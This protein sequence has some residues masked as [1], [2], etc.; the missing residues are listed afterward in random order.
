MKN[1][2]GFATIEIILVVM[3]ISLLS[4]ISLPNMARMIDIARL[5][6]EVKKFCSDFD[7]AHSL[8]RQ[9]EFSAEI[10]QNS[11]QPDYNARNVAIQINENKGTYQIVRSTTSS[12]RPIRDAHILSDGIKIKVKKNSTIYFKPDGSLEGNIDQNISESY[13]FTSRYNTFLV[14][15]DSVG[16]WRGK[17]E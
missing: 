6:Y 5:D 11:I 10:F 16:R 8:G 1:Q 9:T 3:I 2:G 12:E 4:T 15:I 7:F 13:T 14:S 17:R